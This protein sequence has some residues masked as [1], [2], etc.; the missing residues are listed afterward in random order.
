MN[1]QFD[2]NIITKYADFFHKWN[3]EI[4]AYEVFFQMIEVLSVKER[5]TMEFVTEQIEASIEVSKADASAIIESYTS[6]FNSLSAFLDSLSE[7]EDDDIFNEFKSFAQN[8]LAHIKEPQEDI[9]FIITD[10]AY[11]IT[12]AMIEHNDITFND[13]NPQAMVEEISEKL[14]KEISEIFL[15]IIQNNHKIIETGEAT[16]EDKVMVVVL[17]LTLALNLYLRD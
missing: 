5:T 1:T 10:A 9:D 8:L 15:G 3:N 6:Y 2:L 4:H 14:G 7:V 17:Y 12:D 13:E 16:D 11:N